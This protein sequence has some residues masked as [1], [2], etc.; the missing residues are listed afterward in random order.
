MKKEYS[1]LMSVYYKENPKWLD[2]S[3]ESMIKQTEKPNEF[4]LV[5]DGSLTKE[6]YRVIEK[7]TQKYSNLFK[8]V[9]LEKHSGLGLAL[10]KGVEECSNEWI[11]R[12]DS[13][14]ISVPERMEKQFKRITENPKIDIIGANH[15]EFIDQINNKESYSYKKLPS[16]N[17]E[18]QKYARRRNPF[19]HSVVT[20]KKSLVIKSGNY[21]N[22]DY[23]EDYDLWTR[24]IQNGAYCENINE[25]LSYVRVGKNLYKRRG[26]MKYL[27]T[28][29]KF[30]KELYKKGFYSLK[31]YIISSSAHIIMCLVPNNIRDL[32]Y[33]NV[34]RRRVK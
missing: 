33:K 5:E 8:I 15:I 19:S 24:M 34:L 25:Y 30:K 2:K 22:Y 13:D 4:V 21:R 14:D 11:A 28:I 29:L 32:L 20:I 3:I 12:A 9:K 6:L 1:I 10:K 27:K 17:E 31:D 7:Y 26:G 16:T 18:I 23:V